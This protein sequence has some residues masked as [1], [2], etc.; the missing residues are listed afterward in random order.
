MP[1]NCC[2]LPTTDVV[3]LVEGSY[4]VSFYE[5]FT[6]DE[7]WDDAI[8]ELEPFGTNPM[9]A[10]IPMSQVIAGGELTNHRSLDEFGEWQ[11]TY[12]ARVQN[13]RYKW[14]FYTPTC[15]FKIW[16]DRVIYDED[17]AEVSRA[18]EDYQWTPVIADGNCLP[19]GFVSGYL[20]AL[21]WPCSPHTDIQP[22]RPPDPPE[23]VPPGEPDEYRARFLYFDKIRWSFVDGY[24]PPEDGSANGFPV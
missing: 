4:G 23:N 5:Y 24:T 22:P 14:A 13:V 20:N 10:A 11:W 15:Y 18:A 17:E 12:Y 16:F 9:G 3:L 2:E 7:A 1:C 6:P 21:T 19:A 8:S